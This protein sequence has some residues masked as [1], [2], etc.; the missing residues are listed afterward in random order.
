MTPASLSTSL[1]RA[2]DRARILS[3]AEDLPREYLNVLLP[4]MP[5]LSE[6]LLRAL[7][8]TGY[9]EVFLLLD[10]PA[11]LCAHAPDL[12]VERALATPYLPGPVETLCD[13]AAGLAP[14]ALAALRARVMPRIEALED[15]GDRG[16]A[17]LSWSR[18]EPAGVADALVA[19]ALTRLARA[20]IHHI[21]RAAARF[22]DTLAPRHRESLRAQLLA[23]DLDPTAEAIDALACV[24]PPEARP[25][26]VAESLR[27]T[28]ERDR[29]EAGRRALWRV[30][31]APYA[32]LRPYIE[33]HLRELDPTRDLYAL[34]ERAGPWLSTEML[35]LAEARGREAN[36]T[37]DRLVELLAVLARHHPT[38]RQA[39]RDEV[40]AILEDILGDEEGYDIDLDAFDVI[41]ED[42]LDAMR[43]DVALRSSAA[44][45]G[46]TRR[47][48]QRRALAVVGEMDSSYARQYDLDAIQ[49]AEHAAQLDPALRDE[50][51]RAVVA[52]QHRP[53]ALKALGE[54]VAAWPPDAR[55]LVLL[56]LARLADGAPRAGL[57]DALDALERAGDAGRGR[58]RDDVAGR[59]DD[60]AEHPD[61]EPSFE[62]FR[63]HLEGDRVYDATLERVV[64]SALTPRAARRAAV[65]AAEGAPA[66]WRRRVALRALIDLPTLARTAARD[67]MIVQVLRPQ[68]DAL[69]RVLDAAPAREAATVAGWVL[70]VC[71]PGDPAWAS[72]VAAYFDGN[73]WN[74][75]DLL[76][77]I[78]AFAPVLRSLGGD[79]V[80]RA[81]AAW[82][83]DPPSA[84]EFARPW[85]L[86]AVGGFDA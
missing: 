27:R 81:L 14:E 19:E 55:H 7:A 83:R 76:T 64:L 69:H 25:A 23:Q 15:D 56:G 52:M 37:T 84:P 77:V 29:V 70:S 48:L 17:L 40:L 16:C 26:M 11:R 61:D 60:V 82:L 63:A 32:V 74:L 2:L 53:A 49:W 31:K 80:V 30:D 12:F 57:A 73:P 20:P 41:D 46:D 68:P 38:R 10:H 13:G 24:S 28:A 45:D 3:A 51:A 59:T 22:G 5:E 21:R 18:H 75:D 50:A 39:L 47:S 33:A 44:F 9:G 58:P 6:P 65:F 42:S 34:V 67:A 66:W 86:A 1:A 78:T 4:M 85:A 79:E 62:A 8:G 54:L 36:P 35:E 71:G 72:H 43:V